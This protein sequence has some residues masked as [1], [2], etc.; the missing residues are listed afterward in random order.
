MYFPYLY[1]RQAELS[2]LCD[3]V[4]N[5][6]SPQRIIP[7][8]EPA[9]P[10]GKLKRALA[11][12]KSAGAQTYLVVNPSLHQLG[13]PVAQAQWSTDIGP[14]V[15]DPKLIRPTLKETKATTIAD[16]SNFVAAYPGR[17]LG[18]VVSS[19]R[20]P[21][22]NVAGAIGAR[23]VLVLVKPG[24]DSLG[25]AGQLGSSR[26]VAISDN[27]PA[28]ARNADYSGEEWL[29]SNHLAYVAAGQSGFSD[30]TVL[31]GQF[32]ASGGPVGAVAFHLTFKQPSTDDFWIQHFVS[33]E[34]AQYVSTPQA[35][36]LEAVV[37]LQAQISATPSRF[38][39]SPAI[40]NYLTQLSTG[41]ST[42][43]TNNKRLQIVHHLYEV[44]RHLGI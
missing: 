44:A 8:I 39:A 40:A 14:E 3:A 33:D 19:N 35:K 43:L 36:L 10:A 28:Q 11:Q 21:V 37:H 13:S 17:D 22:A 16:I 18:L 4:T 34:Q 41:N 24:V 23:N 6:G 30:F 38:V 27:F 1:G 29:A 25:Y 20:L 26:V 32:S 15:A 12:F 31:P 9:M 2:A 7:V 5:F 42:N